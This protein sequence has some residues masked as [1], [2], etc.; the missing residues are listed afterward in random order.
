MSSTVGAFFV[1][2]LK[3][4]LVVL[5]S[6]VFG[7]L[8]KKTQFPKITGY[9]LCGVLCGPYVFSFL[10]SSDIVH[11]KWSS[12]APVAMVAYMCGSEL[13]WPDIKKLLFLVSAHTIILSTFTVCVVAA[14]VM[15]VSGS[16]SFLSSLGSSCQ[17]GVA[18]L[19]GCLMIERSPT[20]AF[21][22]I[23]ELKAQGPATRT[24]VGITVLTNVVLLILFAITSTVA[25]GQCTLGTFDVGVFVELGFTIGSCIF[26]GVFISGVLILV[27]NIPKPFRSFHKGAL[28]A[29]IG[30]G[31]FYGDASITAASLAKTSYRFTIEPIL[32]SVLSAAILV[33]Y[34]QKRRKFANILRHLSYFVFAIFYTQA[35]VGFDLVALWYGL[36]FAFAISFARLVAIASSTYIC[37]RWVVKSPKL[38]NRFLWMTLLTNGAPLLALSSE[39]KSLG[40]WAEGVA[41]SCIGALIIDHL[42]G[43]K[44]F[45]WGLSFMGEIMKQGVVPLHEGPSKVVETAV[46]INDEKEVLLEEQAVNNG[47]IV[48]GLNPLSLILGVKLIGKHGVQMVSTTLLNFNKAKEIF[49]AKKLEMKEVHDNNDAVPLSL[50][51]EQLNH[52]H[53]RDEYLALFGETVEQERLKTE[54]LLALAPEERVHSLD[55]LMQVVKAFCNPNAFGLVA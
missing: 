2:N 26:V 23:S 35:G 13:F 14:M 41:A 6:S 33:N 47:F 18:F 46:P 4:F 34:S 52:S 55:K 20:T 10:K 21:A 17:V 15:A 25:A 39:L 8:T 16:I 44:T 11:I 7:D 54:E 1:S 43:V 31:V 32:S 3:F 19:C 5:A 48:F 12:Q 42:V 37:G 38:N 49:Y 29:L 53:L 40:P 27:L 28:I 51:H 45:K 36:P 24:L 30:F 22:L 9:L 50:S